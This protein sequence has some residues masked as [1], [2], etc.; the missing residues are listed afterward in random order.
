LNQLIL[1]GSPGQTVVVDVLR[2]GQ[3]IQVYVPRGPIGI[4]SGRGRGGG[5]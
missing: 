3:Q 5:R 2:D 1:D 4:T